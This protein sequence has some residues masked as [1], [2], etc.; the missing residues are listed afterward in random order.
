LATALAP[1]VQLSE[2]GQIWPLE[3]F[4]GLK[5]AEKVLCLV[6]AL[7]AAAMLGLRDEEGVSPGELVALSGMPAGTIRPKLSELVGNRL[8]AKTNAI[9][10]LSAPAARRA[11]ALLGSRNG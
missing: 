3:P 10:S 1:Y 2:D 5:S 7:K 11:I 4:E 6:L 8:L 9:Y